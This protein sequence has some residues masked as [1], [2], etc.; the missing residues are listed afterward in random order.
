MP[1]GGFQSSKR[2]A[3]I[4]LAFGGFYPLGAAG[5]PLAAPWA[6]QRSTFTCF[7]FSYMPAH[8]FAILLPAPRSS[9]PLAF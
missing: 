7:P 6:P 1:G 5:R 2:F 8:A 4:W 9:P 3:C